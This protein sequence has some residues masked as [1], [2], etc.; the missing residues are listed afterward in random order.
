MCCSMQSLDFSKIIKVNPNLKTDDGDFDFDLG[1]N[2]ALPGQGEMTLDQMLTKLP[3]SV[4]LLYKSVMS[5]KTKVKE[6][7]PKAATLKDDVSN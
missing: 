5:I 6:V 1:F 3:G 2:V 7:I 4:Q